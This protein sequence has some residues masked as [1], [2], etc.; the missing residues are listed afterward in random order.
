MLQ[1][2]DEGYLI[3]KK[4]L[5]VGTLLRWTMHD[6]SNLYEQGPEWTSWSIFCITQIK[7]KESWYDN[8]LFMN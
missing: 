1:T 8:L 3:S 5:N 4:K 6:D 7:A 2:T